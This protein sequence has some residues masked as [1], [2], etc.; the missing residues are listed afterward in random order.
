MAAAPQ[1]LSDKRGYSNCVRAAERDVSHL[2]VQRKYYTNTYADSRKFYLN[3]R[4]RVDGQWEPVRITCET[5][6]SGHRVLDVAHES[7]HYLGRTQVTV[8]QN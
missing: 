4:A 3:G 6:R 7:G 1:S 2:D 8:A 5:S